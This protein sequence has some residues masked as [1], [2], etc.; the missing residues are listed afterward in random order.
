[1]QDAIERLKSLPDAAQDEIA[2]RLNDYLTRL[3]ELRALI[4]EGLDSGPAEPLDIE[5][6]KQEAR[7]EW[8]AGQRA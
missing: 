7:A 4:Q 1:M 8:Q 2:P 6:I 3:E 5:A